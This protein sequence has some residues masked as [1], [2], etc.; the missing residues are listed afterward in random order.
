[1]IRLATNAPTK[2]AKIIASAL[3]ATRNCRLSKSFAE[4]H[5]V[6]CDIRRGGADQ[7]EASRVHEAADQCEIQRE[8]AVWRGVRSGRW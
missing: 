8:D 5:E 3:S 2:N 1:M 7:H 6:A 4:A